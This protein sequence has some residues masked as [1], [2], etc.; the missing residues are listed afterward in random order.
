M[1]SKKAYQ[2]TKTLWEDSKYPAEIG[3]EMGYVKDGEVKDQSIRNMLRELRK[4]GI[5]SKGKKIEDQNIQYYVFDLEGAT[6]FWIE[7]LEKRF[8]EVQDSHIEDKELRTETI[9]D[10][11]EGENVSDEKHQNYNKKLLSEAETPIGDIEEL[12]W[13]IKCYKS[14]EDVPGGNFD[15]LFSNW[16]ENYFEKFE[17]STLESMLFD[18]MRRGI[19]Y[20]VEVVNR[21]RDS[22]T[23]THQLEV[24][25]QILHAI[26]EK[27]EA[28]SVGLNSLKQTMKETGEYEG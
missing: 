16:V 22:P 9:E 26:D 24:I 12:R 1:T 3:R 28:G 15:V 10:I 19:G 18:D 14:D 21:H 2:I 8:S 25:N 11:A 6:T 23:V 13:M 7:E 20:G 4:L 5:V 27:T 17:E